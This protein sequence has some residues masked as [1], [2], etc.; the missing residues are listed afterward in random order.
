MRLPTFLLVASSLFAATPVN[1]AGT[2]NVTVRMPGGAVKEQWTIQQKGIAVTGT[3]KGDHGELSVAG[4]IEG[5]FFRVS[6]KDGPKEYKVR[7]TVD[8][9]E[10]EG[11]ITFGVGDARLWF[12]KRP[13]NGKK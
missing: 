13:A 1:V 10:M 7:A 8:G 11:S 12:A 4:T 3:A 6:L 2:W 9:G 5:A